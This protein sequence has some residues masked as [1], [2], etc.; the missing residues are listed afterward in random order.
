MEQI[1][2]LT[3]RGHVA[4]ALFTLCQQALLKERLTPLEEFT[5]ALLLCNSRVNLYRLYSAGELGRQAIH[6]IDPNTSSL[7]RPPIANPK[8]L[9]L[10]YEHF[11][12]SSQRHQGINNVPQ[13]WKLQQITSNL[14][15]E[16]IRIEQL[17]PHTGAMRVKDSPYRVIQLAYLCL[18]QLNDAFIPASSPELI[19]YSEFVEWARSE[20]P[21]GGA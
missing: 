20:N 16:F 2:E 1:A 5:L 12:G 21:D 17:D 4:E 14:L 6:L 3:D 11:R 15:L 19:D 10:A 7:V 18:V 8:M 9:A 13:S